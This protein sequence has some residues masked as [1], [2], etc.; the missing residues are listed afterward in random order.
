M[1]VDVDEAGRHDEPLRVDLLA[2]LS[3]DL[4]DLGNA[5]VLY[6]DIGFERGAARAVEYGSMPDDKVEIGCHGNASSRDTARITQSAWFA[7]FDE[8]FV[9]RSQEGKAR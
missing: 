7:Y 9:G 5:A 3:R 2:T 1:G 8:R 4:A 6:G